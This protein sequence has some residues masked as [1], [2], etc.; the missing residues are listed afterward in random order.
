MSWR[1]ITA[2]SRTPEASVPMT[3]PDYAWHF[4]PGA[5]FAYEDGMTGTLAPVVIGDVTLPTGRVVACDPFV[6]LGSGDIEPFSVAVDPAG[7]G[8][9]LPSPRWCVPASRRAPAR[10][11][12][13]PPCAS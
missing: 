9:R 6:Y 1:T 4:T 10:T 3:P 12:G 8:P 7:T 5:A 13:S 11:P 2:L